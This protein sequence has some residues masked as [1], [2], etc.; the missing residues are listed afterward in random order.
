VRFSVIDTGIGIPEEDLPR[1]FDR[2]WHGSEGGG[3][4]LGLAIAKG[5]VE[6]HGGS[7]SRPRV[8]SGQHV[9]LHAARGTHQQ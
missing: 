9:H 6:A 4:G 5:I 2:F 7:W 8:R 1:I 3:S